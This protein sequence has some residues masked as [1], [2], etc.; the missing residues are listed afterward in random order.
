MGCRDMPGGGSKDLAR[1]APRLSA[2]RCLPVFGLVLPSIAMWSSL[3]NQLHGLWE[4]Y[5]GAVVS[6]EYV[7]SSEL[8][9][10]QP[11]AMGC[12]QQTDH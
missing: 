7:V 10:I 12:G 6:T 2:T 4:A 5:T 8:V 9:A 11:D 3:A 1:A